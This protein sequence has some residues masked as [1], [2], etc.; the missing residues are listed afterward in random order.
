MKKLKFLFIACTLFLLSCENEEVKYRDLKIDVKIQPHNSA[1]FIFKNVPVKFS[2]DLADTTIQFPDFDILWNL[3]DGNFSTERNFYH[4]YSE[5]GSYSPSIKINDGENEIILSNYNFHFKVTSYPIVI[6]ESGINEKGKY[7][8]K[9]GLNYS[10]IYTLSSGS[11]VDELYLLVIDNQY[12]ELSK[13]KMEV[14]APSEI[15]SSFI[16]TSGNIVLITDNYFYEYSRSGTLIKSVLK[17]K[18]YNSVINQSSGYSAIVTENNNI[19]VDLLDFNFNII[20]TKLIK[21]NETNN[22]ILDEDQNEIGNYYILSTSEYE[23]NNFLYELDNQGN[24]I[25]KIDVNITSIEKAYS[26]QIGIYVIGKNENY[27]LIYSIND[28]FDEYS[29]NTYY[30][31]Y[32]NKI[33]F[34]V[35]IQTSIFLDCNSNILIYSNMQFTYLDNSNYDIMRF[36]CNYDVFNDAIRNDAGNFILLGTKQE[37]IDEMATTKEYNTDLLLIEVDNEGNPIENLSKK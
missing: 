27:F 5:N 23:G 16:N 12:N 6:G 4:T 7:I 22:Q 1:G 26:S 25:K 32:N 11:N 35:N 37:V 3:D 28:Y 17:S 20:E 21:F 24:I 18:K 10:I 14:D 36:G 2:C 19:R 13:T 33:Y 15:I 29:Y 30:Y 31:S 34:D 9:N 8:F